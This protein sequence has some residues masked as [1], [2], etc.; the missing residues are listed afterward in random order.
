[1]WTWNW[2]K[3]KNDYD[4]LDS[5]IKKS[6]AKGQ[7]SIINYANEV[8]EHLAWSKYMST[9]AVFRLQAYLV[10]SV[11]IIKGVRIRIEH[12]INIW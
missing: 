9:T 8:P 11:F 3:T 6:L 7:R 5:F 1:M 2:F 12:V 10:I 4:G